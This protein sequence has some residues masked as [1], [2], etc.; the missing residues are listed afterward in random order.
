MGSDT[1]LSE[2]CLSS[3][4]LEGSEAMRRL[5]VKLAAFALAMGIMWGGLAPAAFAGKV[6]N[7]NNPRNAR[8][9]C[10]CG[11]PCKMFCSH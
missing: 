7:C 5:M 8:L 6:V 4:G 3:R 11:T 9:C 10:E 1:T 2:C